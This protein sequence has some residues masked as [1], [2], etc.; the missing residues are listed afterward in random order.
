MDLTA[1]DDLLNSSSLEYVEQM[2]AQY[3]QAP[4]SVPEEWRLY[5][6]ASPNGHTARGAF[7]PSFK[8]SSLFNPAGQATGPAVSSDVGVSAA[9]M[10]Q[11][12]DRLVRNYRVRGHRLAQLSPLGRDPFEVP[13]LDP[14]YYGITQAD[15]SQPV[16]APV[17]PGAETVGEVIEGLQ[18][19]YCRSI[20]AQFMH[21]DS[22]EVRVWLQRRMESSRNR[23]SLSRS[24]QLRILTKLTDATIF[25][26]FIQKK[27]LG[28]KSFSL[29]GS[30]TLIPL[31]DQTIEKAGDQGIEE[32]VLGMA[33][34]GRLNVLANILGKNPRTIFR[35]F[36]DADPEMY[37]GRGDV[38]YHLGYSNDWITEQGKRIH[39][40]LA[41][42]PSHL[43]F[44][45][46]VVLGRSR[47]KGDRMGDVRR[48]KVLPIMIHGDAAFA[49]QGVSQETLNLS[50]LVGYRVGGALHV[51]VNNQVGFTTGPRQGRSTTYATDV[52]K[53]LQIPVFHVNG[54]DP[55]AVAQVIELAMDFR[56]EFRRD[57]VI[58]M[59]AYRRF[60]HNET[61]EPA[62]TQP[63]MYEKI[64]KR[65]GVRESYLGYLKQ[66]GEVTTEDAE[67]VAEERRAH[68]DQELSVAR[69]GDFKLQY[70]TLQGIWADYL[71][72]LDAKVPEANTAIEV[73]EAGRL[74]EAITVTPEEFNLN[75]KIAR[76]LT[77][78]VKMA[79]GEQPLDWAAGEALAFAS[80]VS[81]G[82]KVRMTGQDVERGTFS[83]RHQVFHDSVAGYEF[84]PMSNVEAKEGLFEI[85]NSPLS[86]IAVL[87]YEYGYSLDMPEGL[88]IWEAQYGDFVNVAQVIIDQFLASAEEKWSRLS[89]LVLQLPHA[90][91]GGGPEHSSARL[92]R[93][94]QLC[95]EDNMQVVYPTTPAQIFHLLRRQVLRPY[96]KPLIIMSPK[97]L[98]RHPKA[99]SSLEEVA[100]GTFQR[101]IADDMAD[102]KKVRRIIVTSGKV[103]YDLLA[104]REERGAY[105]VAIVRLEQ[106]Y[107]LDPGAI[108]A[109]LARYSKDVPVVWV[110]E[111][112]ANN[113]AWHFLL[114]RY[115]DEFHGHPFSG[116]YRPESAS[117]A[118]GSGAAHKL[119]QAELLRQAFE[120]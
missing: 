95:A 107:P 21:V 59:Y 99:V 118:T 117:P 63:V 26:D 11:K 19:T 38:K 10:Q 87:A 51:I 2:Y 73:A 33:H 105:D 65:Q 96:R 89:G 62:F 47:A 8:P 20:G 52:A 68:L 35:E 79:R 61:D 106:L 120:D 112:P 104:E 16:L 86:E 54:E 76:Q 114:V 43:E 66:L 71:G 84:L 88:V 60:G 15:M 13:E 98:I 23:L 34:R 17:I 12:L 74:L 82:V 44:V 70:S 78:R 80:L 115:R 110:Q 100:T 41:F 93:F 97:S 64:R 28:A 22:L 57:V 49:G 75:S 36:E 50:G 69:S 9:L 58:D 113:G 18:T 116:V 56:E 101:V 24:K 67:R 72:G 29:E 55:E 45:N 3:V 81:Q 42:N 119:E 32:V 92:E 102:P 46:P 109:A 1:Q 48:D 103:Y 85:H 39:L 27:F 53:M 5:F 40:S 94:L 111:E 6:A 14:S 7:G 90:F 83:H 31:L 4:D 77:T 30:E 37:M 108:D 91:E 25:E